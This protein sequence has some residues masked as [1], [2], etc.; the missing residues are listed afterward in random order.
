MQIGCVPAE[1][2][3]AKETLTIVS[4]LTGK[5]DPTYYVGTVGQEPIW[6]CRGKAIGSSWVWRRNHVTLPLPV[7]QWRPFG[8]TIKVAF[9]RGPGAPK[10]PSLLLLSS[11]LMIFQTCWPSMLLRYAKQATSSQSLAFLSLLS[12]TFSCQV[13]AFPALPQT[14]V[15]AQWGLPRNPT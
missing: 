2:K 3:R 1:E 4:C 11:S 6:G 10:R 7:F 9:W 8:L 14:S 12:I 13:S 5:G 15:P